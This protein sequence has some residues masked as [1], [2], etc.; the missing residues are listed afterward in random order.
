M[1]NWIGLLCVIVF[2]L[3]AGPYLLLLACPRR[4]ADAVHRALREE[5]IRPMVEEL[6]GKALPGKAEDLRALMWGEAGIRELYLAFQT[7][8]DGCSH[9][10]QA[11][12]GEG[13]ERHDFPDEDDRDSSAWGFLHNFDRGYAF[14]KELGLMVFYRTVF[15]RVGTDALQYV[16][17][18]TYPDKAV[19]GHYLRFYDDTEPLETWYDILVFPDQGIV[20]LCAGR[21]PKGLVL[22]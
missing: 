5:E 11:F 16:G 9:I 20:Y 6:T 18:G 19:T 14:Q 1:R 13:V 7:D 8:Q 10:L 3:V 2:A 4:A 17:T 21:R 12:G 15:G 22:P